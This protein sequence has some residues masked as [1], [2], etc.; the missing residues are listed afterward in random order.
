MIVVGHIMAVAM[1]CIQYT[2]H[3]FVGMTM[4]RDLGLMI[5]HDLCEFRHIMCRNPCVGY[6]QHRDRQNDGQHKPDM[7]SDLLSH[8]T[9]NF[10]G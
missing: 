6:Q 1:V 3:F 2:D 9:R 7:K 10:A 5:R 8:F 4:L